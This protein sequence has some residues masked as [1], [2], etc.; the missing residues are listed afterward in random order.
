[1]TKKQNKLIRELMLTFKIG[2]IYLFK[3]DLEQSWSPSG[4]PGVIMRKP[5]YY[6]R[7]V[8][9]MLDNDPGV[10]V[11]PLGVKLPSIF[12]KNLTTEYLNEAFRNCKKYDTFSWIWSYIGKMTIENLT[13]H[14][15]N[16]K[17]KDR[18]THNKYGNIS[19]HEFEDCDY[20]HC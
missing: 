6:A 4:F 18:I 15:F 13:L 7:V 12:P 1:M 11:I 8:G 16:E 17:A 2:K 14:R 3:T 10:I 5:H 20:W 19:R 9:H